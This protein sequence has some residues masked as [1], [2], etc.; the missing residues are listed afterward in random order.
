VLDLVLAV[1]VLVLAA[2]LMLLI[3]I[4]IKATDRGPVLFK[5]HRVGRDGVE[6]DM[7]KFRSMVIDA[8][9]Q[10]SALTDDNERLGPL[11]KLEHDPRVTPI[12]RFLRA[13]SLDELP[14]LI[15]VLWGEMSIVGPRPALPS[16]VAQFDDRL[17]DRLQMPP[18]IT[19]LWQVEARDNPHFG[20]YRRLDLFYVDN[21]SLNLDFVI[22]VA[23]FE[24]VLSKA[25]RSLAGDRSQAAV[26]PMS[27]AAITAMAKTPHEDG[28]PAD[29]EV[30]RSA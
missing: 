30:R 22:L 11:F 2:P 8:E 14:Q 10:L 18:G 7:F 1:P 19:G 3:A 20:A 24:Q 27:P 15:N 29:P 5:Q 28:K 17:L 21:W 4:I 12:G 26:V 6:F 16:E 9:A 23:T 13:T 25:W